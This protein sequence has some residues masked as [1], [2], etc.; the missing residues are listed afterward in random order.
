MPRHCPWIE[1]SN[2]LIHIIDGNFSTRTHTHTHSPNIMSHKFP[3]YSLITVLKSSVMLVSIMDPS[4]K[5]FCT[6]FMTLMKL[7]LGR[8]S[9]HSNAPT[10]Y[11]EV[12]SRWNE[13]APLIFHI[14]IQSHTCHW[15]WQYRKI[16]GFHSASK[17]G[18]INLL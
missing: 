18:N 9:T 16:K 10:T 2:L 5:L 8:L 17:R 14:Y 11:Y 12:A 6:K 13:R 15:H 3:F 4:I 1:L 7:S